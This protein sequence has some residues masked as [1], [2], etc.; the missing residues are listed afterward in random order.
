[1]N[2]VLIGILVVVCFVEAVGD[3]GFIQGNEMV[4]DTNVKDVETQKAIKWWISTKDNK[5]RSLSSCSDDCSNFC[6]SIDG[7]LEQCKGSCVD[8]FCKDYPSES[9]NLIYALSC[10][11][12]LCALSFIILNLARKGKISSN[13]SV[14]EISYNAIR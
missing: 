6:T 5:I 13:I 9:Y 10:V 4:E 8:R 7:K 3:E 11:L 2:K 14:E 1:M 12:A